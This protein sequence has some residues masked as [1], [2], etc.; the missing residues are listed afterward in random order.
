MSPEPVSPDLIKILRVLM[1]M[2]ELSTFSLGGGTSL[3]LRFEHRSSL[4][5]DLFST[6]RFDSEWL[7]NNLRIRFG[8]IEIFNRTVGSL[9]LAIRGVK[10]DVLHSAVDELQMPTTLHGIRFISLDDIAAMK[11]NAVTNRGSKKDFS[12]LLLLH[13]NGVELSMAL[14]FFCQKYGSSGRFLAIRSLQFFEDA[15][16]EPDP[17]YL[18]DWSWDFVEKEM[19]SIVSSMT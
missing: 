5:I 18:N 10:V 19:S 6:E 12:D 2:E 17:T 7:M 13:Q 16:N 8:E 3:A 11:I 4:D 14:D 15:R 1:S 9:C